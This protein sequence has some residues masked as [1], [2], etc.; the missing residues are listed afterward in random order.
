MFFP[1]TTSPISPTIARAAPTPTCPTRP[2]NSQ[3]RIQNSKFRIHNP[4]L[5]KRMAIAATQIVVDSNHLQSSAFH[6]FYHISRVVH[7]AVTISHSRKVQANLRQA[8]S[9]R[10]VFLSIP[11]SLQ[12]IQPSRG[13]HHLSHSL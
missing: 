5:K 10:F 4:H 2:T 12:N 11:I 1:A 13:I 7:L 9:T 6:T 8:V 3:F